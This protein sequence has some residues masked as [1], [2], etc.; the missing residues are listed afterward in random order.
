MGF[1]K[2]LTRQELHDI[3]VRRSADDV[4]ALLW[5]IK[6]LRAIVLRADQ[7]Q[8]SLGPASGGG[9]GLILGCLR[10]ELEGEPCV[11]ESNAL[12]DSTR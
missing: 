6:R 3:G 4:P 1:K 2:P 10:T 5:E 11:I 8:Q 7:L 12:R 9:V